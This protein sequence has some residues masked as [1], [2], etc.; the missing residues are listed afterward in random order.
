MATKKA[1]VKT[2]AAKRGG[3]VHKPKTPAGKP[4]DLKEFFTALRVKRAEKSA[5]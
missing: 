1:P 3:R 4:Q 5:S 2:V